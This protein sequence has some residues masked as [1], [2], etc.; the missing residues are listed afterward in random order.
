MDVITEYKCAMGTINELKSG[1]APK[2]EINLEYLKSFFT[3]EKE[4][5]IVFP[6]FI[7]IY[8]HG[9]IMFRKFEDEAEKEEYEL[10]RKIL[11]SSRLFI[12]RRILG[13]DD[14]I[15]SSL[16]SIVYDTKIMPEI[17]LIRE[18]L[19]DK[20]GRISVLNIENFPDFGMKN[21][22]EIELVRDVL[23]KDYEMSEMTGNTGEYNSEFNEKKKYLGERLRN[24]MKTY[25]LTIDEY[26]H[27]AAIELD[28]KKPESRESKI[29]KPCSL[30][31]ALIEGMHKK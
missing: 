13:I 15:D 9:A 6:R 21:T 19:G 10:E 28:S 23:V 3:K 25:G 7:G 29:Y 5:K 30:L 14:N 20:T 22:A 8:Q 4:K 24:Q 11:E 2:S 26:T 27:L 18:Y 16:I 17:S 31:R 1:K 12:A